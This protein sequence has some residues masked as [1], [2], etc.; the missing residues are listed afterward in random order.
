MK[1]LVITQG[2][3]GERIV[4]NLKEYAPENWDIASIPLTLNLPVIIDEPEDFIPRDIPECDLLLFLSETDAAGQL[5]P[6]IAR[7]AKAKGVVA[8][9]EHS[10]WLS[11]GLKGQVKEELQ[12]DG[13]GS[14]FPKNFCTLTRNTYGYRDS[15][16]PYE[17]EIISEFAEHFGRPEFK[18]NVDTE[19]GILKDIE[20]KRCSPCGS[21]YHAVNKI[22]G[23]PV[24]D[25]IPGAGLTCMQFPCL[26]SMQMEHIDK[27]LY[28]TLMHLSGQ[29]FNDQLGPHL[30]PYYSEEREG[31]NMDH[32]N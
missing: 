13:I 11:Q 6:A 30:E 23:Q 24:D 20:V 31:R 32:E 22:I 15:A 14:A 8:P 3:Y 29:I 17:S 28:N 2:A 5:I 10:T 1:I 18:V 9:I 21:T 19:T 16:E 12:R 27:D 4:N 7:Q 26:A 25:I